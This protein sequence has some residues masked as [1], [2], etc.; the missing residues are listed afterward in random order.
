MNL[1][2]KYY[3]QIIC[4][5]LLCLVIGLTV[6]VINNSPVSVSTPD[7]E[8]QYLKQKIMQ[9]SIELEQIKGKYIYFKEIAESKPKEI[10][11]IKKIYVQI[12]DS[13]TTLPLSGKQNLLADYLNQ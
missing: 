4:F 10:T 8:R 9:D 6:K 3:L 13:A 11:K 5:I 12:K 2:K 7:V 1:I